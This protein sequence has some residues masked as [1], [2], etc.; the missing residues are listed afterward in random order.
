MAGS[1]SLANVGAAN[2][3]PELAAGL[4]G[5]PGFTQRLTRLRPRQAALAAPDSRSRDVRRFP[6]LT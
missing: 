6:A 2:T 4:S 5:E 3:S 1:G